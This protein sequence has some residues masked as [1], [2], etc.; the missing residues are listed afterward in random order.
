VKHLFVGRV[1]CD[2]CEKVSEN[3]ESK[4][5]TWV[6]KQVTLKN[7]RKYNLR[8]KDLIKN[9][10]KFVCTLFQPFSKKKSMMLKRRTL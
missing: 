10:Y 3:V 9:H 7:F 2:V 4:I 6:R 1:L 8:K 5:Q